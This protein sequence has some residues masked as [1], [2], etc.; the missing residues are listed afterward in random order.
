MGFGSFYIR[1][2]F[3]NDFAKLRHDRNLT[4]MKVGEILG[5]SARLVRKYEDNLLFATQG[6]QME[7][8][9]KLHKKWKNEV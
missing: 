9:K 1:D 3:I 7:R 6:D 4:Q 2:E 5:I 8:L